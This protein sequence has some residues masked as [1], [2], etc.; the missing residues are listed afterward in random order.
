MERKVEIWERKNCISSSNYKLRMRIAICDSNENFILQLKK[1]I[2][3]FADRRRLDIVADC[4]NCGE[5][6]IK[7]D[8]KYNLVILD[9]SLNGINGLETAK[10]IRQKNLSAAIIFISKYTEFVFEAFKVNTFRFL[11][12]PI[13]TI[14]FYSVLND[15]LQKYHSEFTLLIKNNDFTSS[16]N[17]Q[18]IFFLEANNKHCT[19]HLEKEAINCNKT[20]AR[21]F[22][23]LP[24]NY[25]SKINRAFV[26]NLSSV[27]RYNND[28]VTLKN[29]TNLHISRKYY[30]TF[31]DDYRLFL[32][33]ITI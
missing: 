29:G 27:L 25:F 5:D 10:K 32:N 19:I 28:I 17:I 18:N 31:K 20:M 3:I 9:Y 14:Q 13:D 11:P 26:I 15:F 30:K 4:Y 16:I 33:P 24:K 8:I 6:I 22:E 12:K 21:V 7:S 2:Y 1:M 23:A